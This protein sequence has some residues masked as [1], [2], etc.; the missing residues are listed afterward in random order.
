MSIQST[1]IR[2]GNVLVADCIEA[3]CFLCESV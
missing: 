3:D 2:D 1:Y